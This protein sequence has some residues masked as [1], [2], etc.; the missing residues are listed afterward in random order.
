VEVGDA[1]F[2]SAA[3]SMTS[4]PHWMQRAELV[5]AGE[6]VDEQVARVSVWDKRA[7]TRKSGEK[8][9]CL[10]AAVFPLARLESFRPTK[11]DLA[12]EGGVR[13]GARVALVLELRDARR[14]T[15]REEE[16]TKRA[17]AARARRAAATTPSP[18]RREA[19]ATKF[20]AVLRPQG[21][22]FAASPRTARDVPPRAVHSESRVE[23]KPEER[24]FEE[25]RFAASRSA[26]DHP[27]DAPL[28]SPLPSPRGETEAEKPVRVRESVTS[29]ARFE[30]P[31]QPAGPR[32]GGDL[33][34]STGDDSNRAPRGDARARADSPPS[35]SPSPAHR[36]HH[37]LAPEV[38]F[39]A[40]TTP[41]ASRAASA[42]SRLKAR[43]RAS[44]TPEAIPSEKRAPSSSRTSRV[45]GS[46]DAVGDETPA[47]SFVSRETTREHEGRGAEGED[48]SP[49]VPETTRRLESPSAPSAARRVAEA[50]TQTDS[51]RERAET[52]YC[53]TAD[54]T[55]RF[56][57]NDANDSEDVARTPPLPV[58]RLA[59]GS[60]VG[61]P[62]SI[63]GLAVRTRA[64]AS[65]TEKEDAFVDKRADSE[66][67]VASPPARPPTPVPPLGHASPFGSFR[68]VDRRRGGSPARPPLRPR[69]R[70]VSEREGKAG[71]EGAR[72]KP[73]GV[74][75]PGNRRSD[76]SVVGSSEKENDVF[77]A[78]SDV[79][80]LSQE[81]ETVSKKT[82]RVPE[83]NK[84]FAFLNRAFAI[85]PDDAYEQLVAAATTRA[86]VAV[87]L[88][89]VRRLGRRLARAEAAL[90]AF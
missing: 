73:L 84:T 71:L 68:P 46:V 3:R 54:P 6:D 83:T 37:R 47:T 36:R 40:M 56:R 90:D 42:N 9:T 33:S 58:R 89:E 39:F 41:P 88:D 81:K 34:V 15:R 19:E 7:S 29:R 80:N 78:A 66:G 12:L 51:E 22:P 27:R 1:R 30:T 5:L 31:S 32:G 52:H 76:F 77:A 44:T 21:T 61:S 50:E 87:E 74:R 65:A 23:E 14:E 48:A 26:A 20:G 28:P 69:A 64:S 85:P 49:P 62:V 35:P 82:I 16:K 25:T 4:N 18:A 38:S 63:A 2:V 59:V 72:P 17:E 60:P 24:V 75:R 70:G 45:G 86:V 13:D 67:T 8:M 55:L 43:A 53:A 11:L 10:G 57:T 79:R